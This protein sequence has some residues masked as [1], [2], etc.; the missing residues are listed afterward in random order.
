MDLNIPCATHVRES[1]VVHGKLDKVWSL[2]RGMKFAWNPDVM[3]AEC[4]AT[5]GVG[6]TVTYSYADGTKQTV[7]IVELSD[8]VHFVTYQVVE[9]RPAISYSSAL[10]KIQL[11]E[12]TTADQV[13]VEWTTDFSND[14]SAAV[15][16]DSR[17]KKH[18]GFKALA[19]YLLETA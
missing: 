16:G 13:F 5:P 11:Y 8:L 7:Q 19:T 18:E 6:S 2:V 17:Y 12:V 3:G 1:T 14:A 4:E 9:S 10:F 15:I